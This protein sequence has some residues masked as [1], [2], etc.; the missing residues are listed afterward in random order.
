VP[1]CAEKAGELECGF[2]GRTS[3]QVLKSGGLSRQSKPEQ[4]PFSPKSL[5]TIAVDPY[6]I[7]P[8]DRFPS[9]RAKRDPRERSQASA[10]YRLAQSRPTS[11][12]SFRPFHSRFS[13]LQSLTDP[14]EPADLTHFPAAVSRIH[15]PPGE[16]S[17]PSIRTLELPESS[18]KEAAS[19]FSTFLAHA[20]FEL[21][22]RKFPSELP[23]ADNTNPIFYRFFYSTFSLIIICVKYI[24]KPDWP[25]DS[26]LS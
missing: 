4:S 9:G 19:Q 24:C 20:R 17:V 16:H 22:L 23:F 14:P 26:T 5:R 15:F 18:P 11:Q 7:A 1:F 12:C 13:A 10:H 21:R 25:S 3:F 8:A 2:W 6:C